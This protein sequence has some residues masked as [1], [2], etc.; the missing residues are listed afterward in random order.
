[1]KRVAICMRGAVSRMNSKF[2]SIDEN[3]DKK[4]AILAESV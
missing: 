2:I 1:M 3:W 4:A